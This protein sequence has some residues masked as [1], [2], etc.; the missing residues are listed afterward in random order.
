M[1]TNLH[2]HTVRSHH[3]SGTEREYIETAL[4][5][6]ITTLGFSDHAPY[7]FPGD[8]YSG[9]R[10]RWEDREDYVN[11]LAALREEYKGKIDIKIGYEL[12]YYPAHFADTVKRL[13][14]TEVDYLILGQHFTNNEYDGHYTGEPTEDEQV[15]ASYVDQMCEAM[16]TGVFTYV[17]HPDILNYVGEDAVYE[18][19]Y[20]R[21]ISH[22]KALGIPMEYNFLGIRTGRHY[23]NDKFFAL[24]GKLG[25]PVCFGFDAHDTPAAFDGDSLVKAEECAAKYGLTVVESPRLAPVHTL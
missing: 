1:I 15:L 6:G 17:A 19:H 3:A 18:K 25:A 7:V 5:G 4:A 10:M 21:L 9:F 2:T 12:E 8:H 11:T 22:A 13:T 23:P 14:E 20:S 16:D 24:C